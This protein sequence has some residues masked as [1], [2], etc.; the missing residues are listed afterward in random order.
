VTDRDSLILEG[1]AAAPGSDLGLA[2]M[3][4]LTKLLGGKASDDEAANVRKAFAEVLGPASPV[5]M[6]NGAGKASGKAGASVPIPSSLKIAAWI[7]GVFVAVI[8][9]VFGAFL[10]SLNS[11]MSEL[12]DG[13]AHISEVMDARMAR[14]EDRV[15]ARLG[16]METRITGLESKI[17]TLTR[18]VTDLRVDFANLKASRDRLE[19]LVTDRLQPRP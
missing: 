15:E 12:R 13:Q 18:L 3:E 5:A 10:L 14:F 9:F 8:T 6:A 11:G 19:A 16:G 2:L 17:E 4:Q 1:G 7:I